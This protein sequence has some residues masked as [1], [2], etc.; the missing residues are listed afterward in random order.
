MR[1]KFFPLFFLISLVSTIPLSAQSNNLID[2][3]LSQKEAAFGDT[4]LL[5]LTAGRIIPEGSGTDTAMKVLAEKFGKLS[6]KKADN[7]I[8]AAEMSFIIMKTFNLKGGIMYMLFP[9]PR[10][11]YRELVYRKDLSGRGGP[12]RKVSGDEVLRTLRQVMDSERIK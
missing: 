1:I 6:G 8:T 5:V 4:V 9:G 2:N 12:Y 7:H 11:A 3:L 10:Y